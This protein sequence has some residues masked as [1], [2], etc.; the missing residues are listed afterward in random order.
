VRVSLQEASS[1]VVVVQLAPVEAEGV[2]EVAEEQVASRSQSL[3]TPS[4]DEESLAPVVDDQVSYPPLPSLLFSFFLWFIVLCDPT[5]YLIY[6][7][8]SC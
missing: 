5:W 4:E 2:E 3:R 7:R 8:N 6:C 1:V